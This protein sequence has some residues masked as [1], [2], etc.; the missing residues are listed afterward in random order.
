MKYE[1]LTY[2]VIG[3]LYETF[4]KLGPGLREKAYHLDF[5]DE[6]R[7]KAIEFQEEVYAPIKINGR[8]LCPQ[9]LDFLVKKI[10]VVELKVGERFQKIH[11]DQV[12]S[13]L[14]TTKKETGLIALFTR[15]G[16]RIKRLFN[17]FLH[18]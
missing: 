4:K 10:L 1:E 18:S 13:Y 12:N 3:L 7:G 2:T 17:N 11:F 15:R 9:F 5:K 16:V 14:R 6:L 8:M